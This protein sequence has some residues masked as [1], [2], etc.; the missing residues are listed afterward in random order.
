LLDVAATVIEA[1]QAPQVV[2][3][4]P[5]VFEETQVSPELVL[6]DPALRAQLAMRESVSSEVVG[7]SHSAA[8]IDVPTSVA[9]VSVVSDSESLA[10]TETVLVDSASRG[11]RAMH[12]PAWSSPRRLFVGVVV[13]VVL[14]AVAS[15]GVFGG[16][17]SA[18]RDSPAD[19][20]G[21]TPPALPL[22]AI[23]NARIAPNAANPAVSTPRPTPTET[24]VATAMRTVDTGPRTPPRPLTRLQ[25]TAETAAQAGIATPSSPWLGW[26]PVAKAS[27]Y[28]IEI[29]HNG[30]SIY[31]AT[32]SVPH[33]HVPG[34]WRR[35]GRTITLA[36]GT[37]RWY[38]WP[39]FRVGSTTQRSTP[40]VV[41]S[42]LEI[43]R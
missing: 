20:A 7:P 17:P 5:T 33:I 23:S 4:V 27:A 36:P 42:K 15:F 8:P 16:S 18:Y 34:R 35:D 38:V 2:T 43:A 40:T 28:A 30:E 19:A 29:T 9:V 39:I 37:Y 25:A 12:V 1:G 13:A 10:N 32:T 3:V 21:P 11:P 22:Q 14:S 41:A 6:V 26:P 24:S 31:S